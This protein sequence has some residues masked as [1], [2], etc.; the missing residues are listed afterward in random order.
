MREATDS[1]VLGAEVTI[2]AGTSP[3]IAILS[4]VDV[5]PLNAIIVL[6]PREVQT[7]TLGK[8]V[9]IEYVLSCSSI[10][11]RPLVLLLISI[12]RIRD[13]LVLV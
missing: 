11:D 5:L 4:D 8:N 1:S 13:H 9:C 2:F 12:M 7:Q 10:V 6:R 3:I